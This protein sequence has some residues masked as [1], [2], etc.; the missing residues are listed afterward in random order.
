MR[1]S[2]KNLVD[3]FKLAAKSFTNIANKP[4]IFYASGINYSV[5]DNGHIKSMTYID[6]NGK[7]TDIDI[8]NP[9]SD[10]FYTVVL[11]DYC[12]QGNDGFTMFNQ[13]DNILEKYPFDATKCVKDVMLQSK[14]PFELVDDGR[15]KVIHE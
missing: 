10:K 4:G 11:N 13:P 8:N 5:S 2:E 6:R 9:K 7:K 1:Y 3:A 15:I 14:E 12:A